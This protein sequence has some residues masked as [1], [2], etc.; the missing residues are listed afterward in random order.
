VRRL[1]GGEGSEAV[2]QMRVANIRKYSQRKRACA[3]RWTGIS[4][5]ST[6]DRRD[7]DTCMLLAGP[8][9]GKMAVAGELG[10]GRS[11]VVVVSEGVAA[12]AGRCV[13][14]TAEVSL[15]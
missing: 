8:G 1:R 5:T 6:S 9:V 7:G 14:L 10:P 2:E 15:A 11:S 4:L 3:R 12:L 13:R